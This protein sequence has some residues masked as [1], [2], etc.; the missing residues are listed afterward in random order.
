[1]EHYLFV[2][3]EDNNFPG[4]T[5]EDFTVVL[6]KMY[7][8][9][10]RWECALLEISLHMPYHE[11]LHVC[12]DIIEDSYVKGY[13]ALYLSWNLMEHIWGTIPFTSHPRGAVVRAS[14][15]KIGGSNP[16]VGRECRSFG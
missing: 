13:S 3:S 4:N 6:P 8:L 9:K 2:S 11:R 1:M 15:A 10:G 16:T 5:P 7:D 14:G 12:Y